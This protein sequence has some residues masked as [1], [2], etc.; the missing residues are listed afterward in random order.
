MSPITQ[1]HSAGKVKDAVKRNSKSIVGAIGAAAGAVLWAA[2][3]WSAGGAWFTFTDNEQQAIGPLV[4]AV[5]AAV[6]AAPKNKPAPSPAEKAARRRKKR[7]NNR[8]G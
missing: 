2:T 5:F 4:L 3:P 7:G 1:G 6:W 8:A